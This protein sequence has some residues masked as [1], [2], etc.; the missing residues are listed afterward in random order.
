MWGITTSTGRVCYLVSYD[1]KPGGT[2]TCVGFYNNW[3]V[4]E[5][6]GNGAREGQWV[7]AGGVADGVKLVRYRMRDGSVS[8][9][10]MG[11]NAFIWVH[12]PGD[13]APVATEAVLKDGTVVRKEGDYGAMW[14][15]MEE[16]A[17]GRTPKH[18][19]DAPT[20]R[21]PYVVP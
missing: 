11:A 2:A 15:E 13:P 4:S 16:R 1:R 19:A 9:A 5:S 6:G 21:A 10:T 20:P 12:N 17:A 3:P 14:A 18:R 7:S 8:N